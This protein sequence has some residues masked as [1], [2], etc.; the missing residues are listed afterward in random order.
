MSWTS[1]VTNKD[2]LSQ[3]YKH[4]FLNAWATRICFIARLNVSA[5]LFIQ[6]QCLLSLSQDLPT[7]HTTILQISSYVD[8][9]LRLCVYKKLNG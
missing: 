8:L 6:Y 4:L 1:P 2:F 3:L 5:F 7:D 9:K